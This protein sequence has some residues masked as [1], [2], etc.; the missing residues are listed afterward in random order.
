MSRRQEYWKKQG[1]TEE[2]IRNHLNFQNQKAKKVRER[3]KK[4]N[5]DNK[6]LIGQIKKDLLNKTF[7]TDRS[8]SKILS[9]NPSVDGVGFWYKVHRIFSDK[10]EG[11]IR[12]FHYFEGYNKKE[13]VKWLKM[14]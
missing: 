5:E 7:N 4:N 6:F 10:S 3:K 13:F 9:I 1:Y 8:T 2:Q 11:D 12:Y 14:I